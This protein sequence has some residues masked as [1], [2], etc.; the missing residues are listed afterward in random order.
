MNPTAILTN[1]HKVIE[2][3]LDILEELTLRAIRKKDLHLDD[4]RELVSFFQEFADKRHH[5]KEETHLFTW[6]EEHGFSR[7]GG[8]TG[9]MINEHAQGRSFIRGLDASLVNAANGNMDNA[10]KTFAT[11]AVGYLNLLRNHIQKEDSCLFPMADKAMTEADQ[12]EM[13]EKFQKTE[14]EDIGPG[15]HEK[16]LVIVKRLAEKYE[17]P[18]ESVPPDVMECQCHQKE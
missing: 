11:Q 12:K 7:D 5:G 8:P 4:A 17:I 13:L 6:M 15:I 9:V 18:I 2:L 10:I 3:A 1:E 16:W 14:V